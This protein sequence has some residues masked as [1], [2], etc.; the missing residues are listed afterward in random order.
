MSRD[1]LLLVLACVLFA[2]GA[3]LGLV[4]VAA[5][6]RLLAGTGGTEPS[7]EP[8]LS[9]RVPRDPDVGDAVEP[10]ESPL[11]DRLGVY[12][13]APRMHD[14]ETTEPPA[15]AAVPPVRPDARAGVAA[16]VT[17]VLQAAETAAEEIVA[18]ARAAA[19]AIRQAAHDE[20]QALRAAAEGDALALRRGAKSERERLEHEG[21]ER[22]TQLEEATRALEEQLGQSLAATRAL[23]RQLEQLQAA[24]S[25]DA[26]ADEAHAES[27]TLRRPRR[28]R[29]P[30]K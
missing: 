18:D 3:K 6:A 26:A 21:F 23:A 9:F 8:D 1:V 24:E 16:H 10:D 14:I 30:S 17:E 19:D 13:A 29:Q 12:S 15:P 4:L 25:D 2:V 11:A 28:G 20:A 5:G 7:D 22:S 27:L